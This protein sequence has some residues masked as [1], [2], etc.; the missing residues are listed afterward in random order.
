VTCACFSTNPCS[1]QLC[2]AASFQGR[3]VMCHG[4]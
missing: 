4:A 1:P 3:A 2:A